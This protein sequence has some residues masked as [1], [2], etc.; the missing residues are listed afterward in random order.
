M[1]RIA[2][3]IALA[4]ALAL[5]TTLGACTDDYGGYGYSSVSVGYGS[6]GYYDGRWGDPYWG[7]YGD[8]YYP[9]SGYYV[10]DRNHRRS[11]WNADQQRYWQG[12]GAGWRGDRGHMRSNWHDFNPR[13]N[14][15]N[16]G[17]G[18]PP[19]R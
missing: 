15:V 12:R 10:Y 7:W 11:R 2:S 6:P 5:G 14:P 18:H 17:H 9:G 1:D 13:G 4:G 16:T 8:Y 3:R 19:R